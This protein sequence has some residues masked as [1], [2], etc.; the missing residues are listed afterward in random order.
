[1][2]R[3]K[4]SSVEGVVKEI[5]S[6]QILWLVWL[7]FIPTSPVSIN[8]STKLSMS[9]SKPNLLSSLLILVSRIFSYLHKYAIIWCCSIV[10][11]VGSH[12]TTETGWI[13]AVTV[14]IEFKG[15][16]I[17]EKLVNRVCHSLKVAECSGVTLTA[18]PN[19]L[20]YYENLSFAKKLRNWKI[21]TEK[22]RTG[23][24]Y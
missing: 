13:S 5:K 20:R 23:I 22:T 8:S 16:K 4:K 11:S 18:E 17:G 24:F 6:Y 19:L 21:I 15:R 1:M 12:R 2:G 10:T 7:K 9:A 3:P 14:S